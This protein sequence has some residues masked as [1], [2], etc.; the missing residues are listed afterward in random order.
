M[1]QIL[2]IP[3]QYGFTCQRKLNQLNMNIIYFC[4][5]SIYQPIIFFQPFNLQPFTMPSVN[6][7]ANQQ[8]NK[9]ISPRC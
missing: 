4:S 9:A 5:K 1:I 6:D 2:I 3:I 8:Y 7:T